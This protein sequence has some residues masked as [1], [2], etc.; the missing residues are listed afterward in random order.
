MI[1]SNDS[2]PPDACPASA[3]IMATRLART[4]L[5]VADAHAPGAPI[6]FANA[7]FAALVDIDAAALVGRS[8]AMLSGSPG[9][10]VEHPTTT[11][12][13]LTANSGGSVPVALSTAPVAA[14][15]GRPFC[16]LCSLIDA[17]GDGVDAAIARDAELL[18]QVADAAGELMRQSTIAARARESNEA[19]ITASQIALN[20]VDHATHAT[21]KE[22]A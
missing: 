5:A 1:H 19:G 7:A 20:A 6:L 4:P 3:V 10:G 16:L 15:D 21:R 14:S 18:G 11:R 2:A 9:V 12:F 13:E 17:R 8:L 22:R